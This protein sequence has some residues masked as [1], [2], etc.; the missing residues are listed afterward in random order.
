MY[1]IVIVLGG[2]P[3]TFFV[4][5][6]FIP[7]LYNRLMDSICISPSR[8]GEIIVATSVCTGVSNSPPDC[9]AAMGSSP[10]PKHKNIPAQM[11]GDIFM[12]ETNGLEPSTSCV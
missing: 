10:V 6:R 8:E 3:P 11:G 9:R 2:L 4:E 7:L 12:V 1:D 5:K